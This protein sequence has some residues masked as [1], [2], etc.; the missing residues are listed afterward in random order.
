MLPIAEYVTPE[1]VQRFEDIGGVALAVTAIAAVVVGIARIGVWLDHRR[2]DVFARKV[3]EVIQPIIDEATLPIKPGTNGGLSLTD[4]HTRMSNFE[5]R[6]SA[7]EA[8]LGI[9]DRREH[10]ED[11]ADLR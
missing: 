1:L 11:Q 2:D 3:K 10:L 7:V 5:D 4:L 8:K 6:F 9:K